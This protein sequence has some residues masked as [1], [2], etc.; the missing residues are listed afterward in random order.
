MRSLLVL[1][2]AFAVGLHLVESFGF[3]V[4]LTDRDGNVIAAADPN[5]TG[6][7]VTLGLVAA[8]LGASR[9]RGRRRRRGGRR[10]R[11][12]RRRGKREAVSFKL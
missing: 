4:N 5:T 1:G 8:A 9:R 2:L 7:L 6:A 10:G 11:R 12:G 3:G